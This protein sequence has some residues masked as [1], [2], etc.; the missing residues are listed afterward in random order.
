LKKNTKTK[1]NKKTKKNNLEKK[2]HVKHKKK[3]CKGGE[4]YSTFP[5]VLI[6][7]N[8]EGRTVSKQ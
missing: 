1:K 6:N 5:C 2:K 4:R 3:T 7:N 8:D